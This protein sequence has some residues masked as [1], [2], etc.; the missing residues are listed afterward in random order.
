MG[1]SDRKNAKNHF[2]SATGGKMTKPGLAG[3][4]LRASC[5]G[6]EEVAPIKNRWGGGSTVRRGVLLE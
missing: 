5:T 1:S 4:A 6:R 3:G 2:P